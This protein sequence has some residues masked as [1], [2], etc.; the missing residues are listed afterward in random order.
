VLTRN[1]Q[2]LLAGIYHYD[3]REHSLAHLELCDPTQKLADTLL[4]P[5]EL[6][7]QA[8]VLCFTGIPRRHEHGDDGRAYRYL[9]LDAGAAAQDVMVAGCA[10]GLA[11]NFVA[12]FYDDELSELLQLDSNNEHPLCLV[13]VGS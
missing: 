1:V 3:A 4:A 2:D 8:V 9:Y 13:A 10:M 5:I 6:D 7:A 12:D 11:T